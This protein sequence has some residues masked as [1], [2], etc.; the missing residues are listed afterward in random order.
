MAASADGAWIA[1]A[2]DDSSVRLWKNQGVRAEP[3]PLVLSAGQHVYAVAFSPDSKYV[4][5]GGREK[6]ALGTLIKHF[7]GRVGMSRDP[8]VRIWRVADGAMIEALSHPGDD[9]HSVA[10]GPDGQWL[11]ASGADKAVHV[12]RITPTSR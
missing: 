6:G 9:V 1:T 11:A 4:A 8:T 7:L 3:D 10:F 12:W 5:S 2:G